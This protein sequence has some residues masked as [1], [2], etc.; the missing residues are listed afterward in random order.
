MEL[1]KLNERDLSGVKGI[2]WPRCSC[3]GLEGTNRT[4]C[5]WAAWLRAQPHLWAKVL[6]AGLGWYPRPHGNHAAST[7]PSPCPLG[8]VEMPAQ[9]SQPS[10]TVSNDG[11]EVG[12]P[13]IVTSVALLGG[14]MP[15]WPVQGLSVAPGTS[16]IGESHSSCFLA[17]PFQSL[18]TPSYKKEKMF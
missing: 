12:G 16:Q 5:P 1:N 8:L 7:V 9:T 18:G 4:V 11:Q 14:C 15:D 6:R 3:Q 10:F 13:V 17:I 2:K